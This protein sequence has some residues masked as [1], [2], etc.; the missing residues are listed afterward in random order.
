[1]RMRGEDSPEK[2]AIT[3]TSSPSVRQQV[4]VK[5][6]DA[7]SLRKKPGMQQLLY[8]HTHGTYSVCAWLLVCPFNGEGDRELLGS[9]ERSQFIGIGGGVEPPAS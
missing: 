3:G 9:H 8:A 7:K 5:A 1:M 4:Y 6:K 2:G